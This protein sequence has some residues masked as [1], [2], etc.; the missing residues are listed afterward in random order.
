MFGWELAL[1]FNCLLFEQQNAGHQE[2]ST[3]S[4]LTPSRIRALAIAN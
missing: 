2:L 1:S 4:F 3:F